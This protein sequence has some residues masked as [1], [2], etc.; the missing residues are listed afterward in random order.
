MCT[1]AVNDFRRD[2]GITAELSL[3]PAAGAFWRK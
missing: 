1:D 3:L 2:A